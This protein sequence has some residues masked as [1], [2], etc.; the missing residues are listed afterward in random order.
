MTSPRDE[1]VLLSLS[2][3]LD[4]GPGLIEFSLSSL[5]FSSSSFSFV[6]GG[7]QAFFWDHQAVLTADFPVLPYVIGC[8]A[9]FLSSVHALLFYFVADCMI[10]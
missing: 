10:D 6:S 7:A 4:C 9:S 5:S 8:G 2:L 1:N 3:S